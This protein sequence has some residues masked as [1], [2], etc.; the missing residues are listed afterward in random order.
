MM[1]S[2][3]W[4]TAPHGTVLLFSHAAFMMPTKSVSGLNLRPAI[5]SNSLGLNKFPVLP[6][7]IHSK[8]LLP[9]MTFGSWDTESRNTALS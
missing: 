8:L 6:D 2:T 5:L 3:L 9:T 4:Y 7:H 1:P